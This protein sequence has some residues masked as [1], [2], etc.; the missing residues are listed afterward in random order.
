MAEAYDHASVTCEATG[1]ASAVD[2]A[3]EW[4]RNGKR[5]DKANHDFTVDKHKATM[6]FVQVGVYIFVTNSTLH[7][8]DRKYAI[9]ARYF[10]Y[11]TTRFCNQNSYGT[12]F[13]LVPCRNGTFSYFWYLK[14]VS[15]RFYS[16]V[17]VLPKTKSK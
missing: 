11:V 9:I 5:V 4:Y 14:G 2:I 15:L 10:D 12:G 3:V 7:D 13:K 1:I 17:Y 16:A 8:G 6:S